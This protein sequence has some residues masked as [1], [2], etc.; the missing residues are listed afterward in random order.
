MNP[1][2]YFKEGVKI[3]EPFM[4]ENGFRFVFGESGKGSGGNYTWGKFEKENRALELHFRYSLGCVE[5]LLGDKRLT[6]ENYLRLLGVYGKNHYP[7]FSDDPFQAFKDLLYDLKAYAT[8][9][10]SG[11]GKEFTE[12]SLRFEQNPDQFTG[13]RSL[14]K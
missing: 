10:I 4:S 6:H 11:S 3:L 1:E 8:D 5:Y 9:F 12:L 7:G 2:Y 14:P 13:F